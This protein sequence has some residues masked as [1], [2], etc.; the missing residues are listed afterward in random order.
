VT[1]TETTDADVATPAAG[2]VLRRAAFWVVI[3]VVGALVTIAVLAVTRPRAETP[4]Y[5]SIESTASNGARAL[6]EVLREQ[7]VDV[8]GT[9]SL[10]A[11]REAVDPDGT[12]I[13]LF[14]VY[15]ILGSEQRVELLELADTLVVIEPWDTE[16]ADLAPGV[17][18]G[19]AI[20]EPIDD[21]CDLPAVDRAGRVDAAGSGYLLDDPAGSIGCLRDSDGEFGLVVTETAG[22]RVVVLGLSTALANGEITR[23][24]NA[25]LALNL[26]GEHEN[27]VW[28]VPGLDDLE[29]EDI[30]S[31]TELTPPWVTPLAIL[32]L[33]VAIAAAFWRGRRMGPLVVENLPVVVRASETVE[34][35]ARLYERA[36]A[37]VHSV[38]ALRIGAIARIAARCGLPRT[39]S[40]AQVVD[41]VATLLGRPRVEIAALLVDAI[42][43][44]DAGLVRLSDGL[45]WLEDDIARVTR[46]R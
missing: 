29:Q 41:A 37:R 19:G 16:L 36:Q 42:P 27:L 43:T 14:D 1:A 39:A 12:T 8:T 38:D 13:V 26:L 20:Y 46:A 28:Y 4:D 7:G 18:Q 25:A 24:G 11:T 35:R 10:A 44:D 33:L 23:D 31:I 22:T 34:G 32:A 2:R 6:V 30:P 40:V 15:G 17:V 5:L 9:A 3:V 21:D 45:A